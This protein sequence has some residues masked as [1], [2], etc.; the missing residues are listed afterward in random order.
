VKHDNAPQAELFKR[1]YAEEL[2]KMERR[3]LI[4]PGRRIVKGDWQT[5]TD[6]TTFSRYGRLVHT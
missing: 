6:P 2:L 4:T 5:S 3:Y 1:R